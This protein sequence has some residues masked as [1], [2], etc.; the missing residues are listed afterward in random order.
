M[1]AGSTNIHGE[2]IIDS[3]RTEAF[4]IELIAVADVSRNLRVV[5][6][7]WR[8]QAGFAVSLNVE[9]ST[10]AVECGFDFVKQIRR[11]GVWA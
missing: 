3:L 7:W 1:L 2:K 11:N 8:V 4:S 5:F 10:K 6:S 9:V